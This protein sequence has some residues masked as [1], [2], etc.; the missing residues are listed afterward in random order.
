[1]TLT[2]TLDPAETEPLFLQIASRMRAA[3][4]SGHVAAGSKLPSARA[5]AAQL[6]VARGT[7]DAAYAL[8]AGEGAI[9]TRGPG[10]TVVSGAV[11]VGALEHT[12]F[13]FPAEG[14]AER[15]GPLPFQM[16]LPAL[17]EF[18]RKL[19]SN[20]TVQAARSTQPADLAA[21][22]PAGL[23][24][25]RQAIAAY[26]AVA[27]G[28]RCSANE[29]LITAGYQ[30]ALSLVH[31]LLVR[32]G[33]AV[34]MEDPGY[35]ITRQALE[36]AGARVVPVRVDQDGMRVASGIA[37]APRAK[38]AVVTPTHQCP[39]GVALSLPRRMELLAWAG[40]TGSWV[41]E[42]DYDSEF[43]YA[44]RPL[45]SLKSLDRGQRVLYAGTF[46]KA[47]F[48]ALRLGYLVVPPELA[49]AFLRASRLTTSGL[50]ALEQRVVSSFMQRGHFPRHIRRMRMLYAKR[51]RGLALSLEAAFGGN[52]TVE[53]AAGGMHLLVRLRGDADDTMLARRAV[54][55]G[56]AP[57]TLSSHTVVHDRGP[58]LL[59]S[60][61]NIPV[62]TAPSVAARLAAALGPFD[63][64]TSHVGLTVAP[65][66]CDGAVRLAGPSGGDAA[67]APHGGD[68][69]RAPH[70]GDTTG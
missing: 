17:D 6:A 56:L 37:A 27:R 29:V 51:R 41:L 38:L 28:I 36:A 33:D 25:L 19:W 57:S 42:D 35:A 20:L 46:S 16:G 50:P 54:A 1:M 15:K 40:E 32:H 26:L 63:A 12:P 14:A 55:A 7:V 70:G 69:T 4:V 43:R 39:T 67:R 30:G 60:F 68:T 5:L 48:P 22:D 9:D 24:D 66:A 21:P 64:K 31:G 11:P 62:E 47:L 44:G 2:F 45:P 10:G 61:T 52:A 59:L 53:M 65:G 3:I 58:G 49:A 8:L 23:L 18:P 34:W 13:M